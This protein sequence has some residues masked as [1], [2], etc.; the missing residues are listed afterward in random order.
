M[1]GRKSVRNKFFIIIWRLKF[2]I[3]W[4]LND[5]A[6]TW[7]GWENFKKGKNKQQ[8][9]K[10]EIELQVINENSLW[11]QNI[12]ITVSRTVEKFTSGGKL[13]REV[14]SNDVHIN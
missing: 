3:F 5:S 10:I 2:E 4:K 8:L 9:S 6:S 1:F 11:Q 12:P 14:G 13:N 7:L